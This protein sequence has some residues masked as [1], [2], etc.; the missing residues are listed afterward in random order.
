MTTVLNCDY[1]TTIDD[2]VVFGL[3]KCLGIPNVD[4]DIQK[5][6]CYVDWLLVPEVRSW[7]IKSISVYAT[8]IIASVEWEVFIEDLNEEEKAVLIAANGRQYGNETI[9]GL[10]EVDTREEWNGNKWTIES[11]FRMEEDGMC[12]PVDVEIDFKNM[13]II[14]S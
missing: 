8:K 12:K 3:N 11:D 7:G 1:Q 5:P 14:V 9:S 2:G 4:I 10:I 6:T 13:K